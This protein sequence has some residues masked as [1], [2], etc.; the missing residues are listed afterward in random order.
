MFWKDTSDEVFP[1]VFSRTMRVTWSKQVSKS[2]LQKQ[3]KRYA[4]KFCTVFQESLSGRLW[5]LVLKYTRPLSLKELI[6]EDR[7]R[8]LDLP[9]L[10]YRRLRG[11]LIQ[12]FKV[13]NG[14]ND[15]RPDSM[16]ELV[17]HEAGTRGHK[18]KIQ[19]QHTRL[20]LREHSF[21]IRIVNLWNSLTEHVV[22]AKTLNEFKNGVDDAL[23]PTID[24]FTYSTG[25]LW[26]ALVK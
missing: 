9:T 16:F 21:S 3:N 5:L 11:D 19:K 2:W 6:Y 10:A 18:Y 23:S 17:Q 13:V 14:L 7:L 1:L 8:H 20:R 4:E 24:K 12:V 22:D 25:R 15:I 26:Q